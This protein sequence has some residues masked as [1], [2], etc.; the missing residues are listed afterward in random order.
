MKLTYATTRFIFTPQELEIDCTVEV[1]EGSVRHAF[2]QVAQDCNLSLWEDATDE[3][4]GPY[5]QIVGFQS[6]GEFSM[7]LA[8][9]ATA[10]VPATMIE[11]E[12]TAV[13]T[14]LWMPKKHPL[15]T[16]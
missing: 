2:C 6:V 3:V 7:T 10:G 11:T 1:N 9:L 16:R 14:L 12:E 4:D 5:L 8:K 13:I 15:A